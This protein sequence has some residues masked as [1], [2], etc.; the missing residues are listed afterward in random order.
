MHAL[1]NVSKLFNFTRGGFFLETHVLE[2]GGLQGGSKGARAF[3]F[4]E[5]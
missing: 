1:F 3:Q 2:Q 4:S 5:Q